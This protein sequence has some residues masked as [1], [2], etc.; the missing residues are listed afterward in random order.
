M[1]NRKTSGENQIWVGDFTLAFGKRNQT[2]VV[3]RKSFGARDV[4]E[5]SFGNSLNRMDELPKSEAVNDEKEGGK[6]QS[7]FVACVAGFTF[8]VVCMGL[9]DGISGPGFF[10]TQFFFNIVSSMVMLTVAPM[11]L[12]P[13]RILADILRGLQVPRGYSDILLGALLGSIMFLP[14]LTTDQAIEWRKLAFIIGGGIGGFVYWRSRG[15]PG[16]RSKFNAAANL[17]NAGL[18]RL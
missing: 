7:Y 13:A 16:M 17:A 3:E 4:Q 6:L 9:I 10:G 2:S 1:F 18:K 12:I 11:L 15:F 5:N 14:D 8:S